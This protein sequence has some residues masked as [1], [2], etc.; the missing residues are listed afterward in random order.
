MFS[1]KMSNF[2]Y[3]ELNDSHDLKK[4]E[5]LFYYTYLITLKFLFSFS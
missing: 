1:V 3:V 2:K 4:G 5:I